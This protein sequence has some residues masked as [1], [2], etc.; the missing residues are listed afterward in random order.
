MLGGALIL[1]GR[2]FSNP[3]IGDF[4]ILAAT[5]CAP[6]GNLYQQKAMKI[7]SSEVIMFGRTLLA[8][9]ILFA[10]LYFW[11]DLP[12][13]NKVF[14]A[15]T[16]VLINGLLLLGFSK[17]LW[18]EAIHRISVTKA[19][20]ISILT[21]LFTLLISWIV[22]QQPPTSWQLLSVGPFLGGVLLLTGAHREVLRSVGLR[23]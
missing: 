19:N 6:L 17:L 7:A 11:E 12:E 23:S 18:V 21:P 2:D 1:L 8:T 15:S 16:F 20:A 9:P 14:E 10:A 4:C 3:N 5:I 13:L 22:L